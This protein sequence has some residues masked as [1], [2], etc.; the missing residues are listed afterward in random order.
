[1]Q[2]EENSCSIFVVPGLIDQTK[3]KAHSQINSAQIPGKTKFPSNK[4]VQAISGWTS[5]EQRPRSAR[6]ASGEGEV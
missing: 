5:F 3:N 1:V 6:S 4:I 2:V